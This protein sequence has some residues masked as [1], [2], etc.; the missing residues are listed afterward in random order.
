M[1]VP[2]LEVEGLS[3]TYIKR[4]GLFRKEEIQA[5]APLSFSLEAGK[6]LA[7]VGETGS[8]K[9]TV[10]KLLV[11]AEVPSTGVVKLDGEPL[12]LH[13]A[14]SCRTI[15]MIFQDPSTSLNPRVTIG[16][17]LEEPLKLNT[18]LT[19]AQRLAKVEATLIRVGLLAEHADYYPHMISG[20]QKQRVALARAL[21]LNPKI[22][23]CDEALA[24]LDVSLRGQILNFLLEEQRKQQLGYVF[25]S[26]NMGIV[27]H[28]SDY[29]LVMHHGEVVERGPTE[30][31]FRE[32][33][34]EVTKR[35]LMAQNLLGY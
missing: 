32:P 34:H 26:H 7:I 33:K 24:A 8:G 17:Q 2:L 16:R 18:E 10:A 19:P 20:G 13:S 11:G 23:I 22:L 4:S 9:T 1:S 30:Q 12:A 21:I 31:V 14:Q 25:V 3:K 28:I 27:R 35:M 5:V 15:R 6:T 29:V